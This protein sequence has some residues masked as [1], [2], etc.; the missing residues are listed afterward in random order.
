MKYRLMQNVFASDLKSRAV[1]VMNY[2][3]F[4]ANQEL[5][6]FPSIKT[7]AKE[8][9]ISVNTVKRALDDL[10]D[11]GYIKKAAR[12]IEAKNGAQTSNLYTLCEDVLVAAEREQEVCSNPTES[13]DID[14]IAREDFESV[15]IVIPYLPLSVIAIQ[16]TK[17]GCA[18]KPYPVMF[19]QFYSRA[20]HRCFFVEPSWPTPQPTVRPP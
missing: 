20:N 9:H 5:T 2:L 3:V 7:I 13:P 16:N 4:R 15:A 17:A 14:D 10:V 11:A 8:C 19:P 6:C 18:L 1:L 12:F